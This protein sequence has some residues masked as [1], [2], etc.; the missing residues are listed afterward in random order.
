M[1]LLQEVLKL[2]DLLKDD[3]LILN[4]KEKEQIMLNDDYTQGLIFKYQ[5]A[6]SYYNDAVRYHLDLEKYQL[7]LSKTKVPNMMPNIRINLNEDMLNGTAL[8]TVT[9]LRV[10][11]SPLSVESVITRSLTFPD[12]FIITVF[13]ELLF[14]II[15]PFAVL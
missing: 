5:Q 12:I 9:E 8:F 2:K 14:L 4:V 13:V 7:E 3:E 10:K 1:E 6:M 15:V 11:S